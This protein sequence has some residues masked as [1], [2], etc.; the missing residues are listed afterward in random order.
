MPSLEV[1]K[2]ILL[3]I[4]V[5]V[6]VITV[7]LVLA[8]LLYPKAKIVISDILRAFGGLH[9]WV[10]RKSVETEIEGSINSFTSSFNSEMSAQLCNAP[11]NLDR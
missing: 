2:D 6:T 5:P 7:A 4:G 10:R 9:K 11:Q 8:L 1:I 3:F